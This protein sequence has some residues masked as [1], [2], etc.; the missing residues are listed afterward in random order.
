MPITRPARPAHVLKTGFTR[1]EEGGSAI[2]ASKI[3]GHSTV[4]QTGDYTFVRLE[5]QDELTRAMQSRRAKANAEN[6]EKE[7]QKLAN[8]ETE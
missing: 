2:E 8:A 4:S 7:A 1:Q 6:P 5:R 3:A